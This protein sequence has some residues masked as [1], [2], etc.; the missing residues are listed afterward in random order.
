LV[1]HRVVRGYDITYQTFQGKPI[2]FDHYYLPFTTSGGHP[3]LRDVRAGADG[4]TYIY[5]SEDHL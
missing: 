4:F 2:I 3:L 1:G 5:H